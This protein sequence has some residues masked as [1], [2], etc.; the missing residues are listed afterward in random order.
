M[1]FFSN[2]ALLW[3]VASVGW[4]TLIIILSLMPGGTGSM[5][6]FGIPHFDKVGH[7]GM[8]A[9]WVF[10]MVVTSSVRK[11][12]AAGRLYI[13]MWI[14]IVVGAGLEFGQRWMHQGRSFE[15]ADMVANAAGA[16]AGWL[17]GCWVVSRR[18]PVR[19]QAPS[20]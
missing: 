2:R 17:V 19:S 7:F 3:M 5:S 8:Y 9:I 11:T 14:G 12:T 16:F 20:K 10:I 1:Q 13:P 6:F 4:A 18:K 15:V